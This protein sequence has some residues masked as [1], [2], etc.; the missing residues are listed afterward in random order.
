MDDIAP[1]TTADARSLARLD[2]RNGL[3]SPMV[4]G[5]S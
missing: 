5:R 3:P 2:E 4:T 1:L